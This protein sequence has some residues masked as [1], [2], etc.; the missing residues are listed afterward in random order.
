M[1][2]LDRFSLSFNQAD[3][4]VMAPIY[5]AGEAPIDGVDA[6]ILYKGIKKHGHREVFLCEDR[7]NV[8]TTVLGLVKPDDVVLTL[9]AG[10]IHLVGNELLEEL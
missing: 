4:L 9:G 8:L 2:L 7:N 3:L 6:S 10:D 5:A 1:A